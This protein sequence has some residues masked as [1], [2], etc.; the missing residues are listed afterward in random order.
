VDQAAIG[1][2]G[3]TH[4]SGSAYDDQSVA[5]SETEISQLHK[6]RRTPSPPSVGAGSAALGL[7]SPPVVLFSGLTGA[8]GAGLRTG[9]IPDQGAASS[10]TTTSGFAIPEPRPVAEPLHAAEAKELAELRAALNE[11]KRYVEALRA[12]NLTE[13]KNTDAA[14]RA[15]RVAESAGNPALIAKLGTPQHRAR[16]TM[17]RNGSYL[18]GYDTIRKDMFDVPFHRAS[19]SRA[20]LAKMRRHFDNLQRRMLAEER[21]LA[22]NEDIASWIEEEDTLLELERDLMGAEESRKSKR[23]SPPGPPAAPP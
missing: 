6:K 17:L 22:E 5:E 11:S 1:L 20:K 19:V 13:R 16:K 9:G 3:L 18:N 12:A 21:V 2:A 14:Q 8:A 15:L 23:K 4:E 7:L 10:S